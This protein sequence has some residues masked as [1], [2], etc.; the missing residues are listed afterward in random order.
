MSKAGLMMSVK[1]ILICHNSAHVKVLRGILRSYI[2]VDFDNQ[3]DVTLSRYAPAELMEQLEKA[4]PDRLKV[5][6][7]QKKRGLQELDTNT[8]EAKRVALAESRNTLSPLPPIC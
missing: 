8:P 5:Y 3:A 2:M 1:Q 6:E 7:S 4:K